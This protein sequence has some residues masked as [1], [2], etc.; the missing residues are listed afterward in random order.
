[1]ARHRQSGRGQFSG[2]HISKRMMIRLIVLVIAGIVGWFGKNKD[3]SHKANQGSNVEQTENFQVLSNCKLVSNKYNDGDS[4]MVSHGGK[5][6]EFRLYYAD[7][8][9]SKDKP[10]DDHQRRV[11]DQGKDLGGLSYKETIK[12][13]QEASRFTQQVLKKP[14]TIYTK[15][16]L[17]YG[18]PRRYAFVQVS[19]DG[20]RK[21]LHE[22]LIEKGL[23]RMHTKGI[24]TP[25][26]LSYSKQKARLLKMQRSNS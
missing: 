15:G 12:L 13:G 17:V 16:E 23:G 2:G 26:G 6:T 11:R 14:F 9:E 5:Q 22:L 3:G 24:T 19:Y 18:G 10:Y 4:F 7:T 8:P 21:W 1:M 20:G 25:D